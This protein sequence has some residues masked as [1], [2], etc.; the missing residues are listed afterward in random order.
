MDDDARF[1][2]LAVRIL[3]A[4]GLVVGG[5]ADSYESG[6]NAA[7]TLRPGG[8]LVD[9]RLPDGDGVALARA[10]SALSW[11]PQVV[12]TS[13]DADIAAEFAQKGAEGLV[14]IPKSDLPDA[15]LRRLLEQPWQS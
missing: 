6:W 13:S 3:A 11:R 8:V 10:L 2:E 14:F 4:A 12:L 5:E 15:P 9:A 7:R 1:R